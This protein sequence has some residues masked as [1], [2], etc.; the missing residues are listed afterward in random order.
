MRTATVITADEATLTV[1]GK[2]NIIGI[3]TA[4]I[5]I[6]ID[7]YIVGQLVFVFVVETDPDNRFEKLELRIDLPGGDFRRL[8]VNLGAMRDGES[9]KIRWSLKFPLLFQNAVLKPG[10]IVASVIHE[11][12]V[13]HATAPVIVHI[14]LQALVPGPP[15]H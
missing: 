3:Y 11:N 4:D 10:P 2:L 14:P 1:S 6:P 12:G 7:P 15:P 13:I 9:D 8:P 5:N